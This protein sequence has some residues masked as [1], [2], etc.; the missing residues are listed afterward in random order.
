MT[1][2][3][4]ALQERGI[5]DVALMITLTSS[6]NIQEGDIFS[7]ELNYFMVNLKRYL[8]EKHLK[9]VCVREVQKR[10][11]YHYHIVLFDYSFIPF[12]VIDRFWRLGYVW[13]SKMASSEAI[14]YILKY[15]RK[16]E[17]FE[18][19]RL[20]SSFFFQSFFKLDYLKLKA[21]FRKHYFFGKFLD[22]C[23][24]VGLKVFKD[25]KRMFDF[26]YS[27]EL[28]CKDFYKIFQF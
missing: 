22:Y 9:Y 10:G 5:S 7:R 3:R 27:P 6:G 4:F 15:V 12:D 25:I 14:D 19:V 24:N 23:F 26:A 21:W 17:K 16:Q 20:H 2:T 1:L 18:G 13:V 8:K 28:S 11:A